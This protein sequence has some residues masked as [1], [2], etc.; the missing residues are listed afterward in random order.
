[1]ERF[2]FVL[3][4]F[5]IIVSIFSYSSNISSY[6]LESD[7]N[8]TKL[9][10]STL[11]NLGIDESTGAAIF[12]IYSNELIFGHRERK[13]FIPA[14]IMKLTTTISSLSFLGPFYTYEVKIYRKDNNIIIS[15]N[16]NPTLI[17][18][19]N[20]DPYR[21]LKEGI[22]NILDTYNIKSIDNVY[23][24]HSYPSYFPESWK[25]YEGEPY[26][27]YLS[28]FSF[29]QNMIKIEKKNNVFHIYPPIFDEFKNYSYVLKLVKNLNEIDGAYWY[30]Y[31]SAEEYNKKVIESIFKELKINCK[32]EIQRE[33]IDNAEYLGSFPTGIL[34]EALKY[35]NY[36]SDN[37]IAQQVYN[38]LKYQYN[39]NLQE[40]YKN[41]NF[42]VDDGCGLSRKNRLNPYYL[43]YLLSLMDDYNLIDYILYTL[44]NSGEGTLS[45]R[46]LPPTVKAKTGT[47]NDVSSLAGYIKTQKGN[48]YSFTIIY[49]GPGVFNAKL[50]EEQI[51]FFI[52]N[53][54]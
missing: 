48:W 2:L 25:I 51:L 29:N 17:E 21:L 23:L 26:A 54:L 44:P 46:K 15:S 41:Y 1:M 8:R 18:E 32:A 49:N 5:F 3:L 38:L 7:N 52:Y 31:P 13:L 4:L 39:I 16:Y 11:S 10:N 14:S 19:I 6:P 28:T 43:A 45:H 24:D 12:D 36:Y 9:I 50:K 34:I 40:V 20:P 37:F 27:P 30:I 42:Y 33:K 35:Q 22:K 53:N 47:L